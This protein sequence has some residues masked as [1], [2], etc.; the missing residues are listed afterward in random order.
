MFKLWLSFGAALKEYPVNSE[1][2]VQT[3]L[4]NEWI[5]F[6]LSEQ[7]GYGTIREWILLTRLHA[8]TT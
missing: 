1:T 3:P 4:V 7:I 6:R 5:R 2:N 8:A